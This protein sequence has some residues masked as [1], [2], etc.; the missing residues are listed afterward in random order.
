MELSEAILKGCELRPH[1]CRNHWF[2]IAYEYTSGINQYPIKTTLASCV[3]AAAYEGAFGPV[4]Y[5]MSINKVEVAMNS[6]ELITA[7]RNTFPIMSQEVSFPVPIRP[8]Q[9]YKKT[10][11][12]I[13]MYLNDTAGWTREQ[14]AAWLKYVVEGA[15]MLP[16]EN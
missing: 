13:V 3:L 14:V 11:E 15:P 7:L 9:G 5:S 8:D 16:E 4:Q 2:D 10:V 6:R 1:G 12:G